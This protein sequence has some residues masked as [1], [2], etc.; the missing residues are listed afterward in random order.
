MTYTSESPSTGAPEDPD[1]R[2]T[3][4]DEI[5]ESSK[6]RETKGFQSSI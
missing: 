6:H 2:P 1:H 4:L 3:A 5:L